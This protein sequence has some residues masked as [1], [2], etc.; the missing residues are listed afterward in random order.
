[1]KIAYELFDQLIEA[2]M[3]DLVFGGDVTAH[4]YR[5]Y[6][7][8]VDKIRPVEVL[9]EQLLDEV[10]NGWVEV[11]IEY[12][13]DSCDDRDDLLDSPADVVQYL[14][15]EQYIQQPEN[16]VPGSLFISDENPGRIAWKRA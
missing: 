12:N 13:F 5:Y 16:I 4:I 15:D 3:E 9:D 7:G 6:S 14:V 10:V 11:S 2:Q 8:E 1:M